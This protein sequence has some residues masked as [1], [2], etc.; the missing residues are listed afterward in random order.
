[1]TDVST[2]AL[3]SFGPRSWV[4]PELS[5][6]GRLPMTTYLPR[7]DVV[8]L[9]GQWSF[10]LRDR[11]EHVLA[12]D[13]RRPDRRLG[14]GGGSRLLDDAGLR[15]AAVHERADAVPG[16]ASAVPDDN[17]DR[18]V[19][20]HSD[21][22]AGVARTPR[23]VARRRRG[24]GALRARRRRT[25]RHG[26]GLAPAARVRR[27]R[28]RRRRARPSSSRSPS[29]AGRTRPTSKTR[30]TG[31]TPV[32][33]AACSS[34]RPRRCTSP[35]CTSSPTTNRKPATAGSHVRVVGRHAGPAAEAMEG[36][37]SRSP[38]RA[39]RATV[40][41]EHPNWVV[42]FLRFE[43]R[44]A[45]AS[46]TVPGVAPWT[47][48]TPNLHEL[49]VTLVDADDREIDVVSLA[50][51]FRRVEVRGRELLVNGRPVLVKGVNRHDHDPRRGKAVTRESIEAD[52]DLDEAAQ[53]QRDPHVALSERRVLLR[54]VRSARHVRARRGQRRDARL[55][56]QPH[57]GSDVGARQCSSASRAWRN[58]TR[59]TLRSS[60]GRS[61]TRAARRRSTSRPRRGCGRGTRPGRCT[62][63][64]G[65]EKTSS[66]RGER[67]VAASFARAAARDRRDRA[68]VPG[69]R[70]TSSTGRPAS[71]PT[72]R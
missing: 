62:T 49:T 7:R 29:C 25:G 71:R 26:Q 45:S 12:D 65:W 70:A 36:A 2:S 23:R 69:A 51:G 38:A 39:P 53:H 41:F 34:T 48:E 43:G 64:A 33:T 20:P 13:V 5:G 27:H 50:V 37:R 40:Y 31:I 3:E 63:K 11:P 30:I 56:A 16:T 47:A 15:L 46:L 55:P 67:D 66:R 60:C 4:R 68:D 52:V 42:N 57:Q 35:T 59:T 61:A 22:A 19:P 72:V 1:M 21:G 10:A 58:A 9:D 17:P 18:C 8:S 32:C 6:F 54:R 28:N 24:I 14:A 44:G